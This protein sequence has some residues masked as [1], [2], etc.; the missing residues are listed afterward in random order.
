M[1]YGAKPIPP[2]DRYA[3]VFRRLPNTMQTRLWLTPERI[4]RS[5]LF[6]RCLYRQADY[7]TLPF[8]ARESG[9]L[10][11]SD[12]DP[13]LAAN[14]VLL[15]PIY[16]IGRFLMEELNW[17]RPSLDHLPPAITEVHWAT[18]LKCRTAKGDL[19]NYG[20]QLLTEVRA[21][22]EGVEWCRF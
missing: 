10:N 7:V 14:Q 11:R 8:L 1:E 20:F 17:E 18:F 19:E 12:I 22:L 16:C 4:Q 13:R 5:M 2:S 6:L 9:V 3:T 15:G 21:A